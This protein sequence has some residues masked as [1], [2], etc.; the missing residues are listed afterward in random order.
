V[1]DQTLG[2]LENQI[3]NF[4]ETHNIIL[5]WGSKGQEPVDDLFKYHSRLVS[6]HL[7]NQVHKLFSKFGDGRG[8][9]IVNRVATPYFLNIGGH[10][11][12]YAKYSFKDNVCHDSSSGRQQERNNMSITVN[13][14]GGPNSVDCDE[15]QEHRIKNIKG[16]LD[17]LHGNH[18]PSNIEKA[19][20]SADLQLK[21]S[22]EIERAMNI[23]YSCAGTASRLLCDE[24]VA[25]IEKLMKEIKPFSKHR[26]EV[27]FV[28][29]LLE[30]DNFAKLESKSGLVSEF[31]ERNRKQYP[32]WG[33]F[34]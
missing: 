2:N 14:W 34:V 9:R 31:L 16:F 18:D 20:K 7:M 26:K 12:K 4:L 19:V 13:A 29:P 21:I 1:E 10:R 25:K 23:S 27:S 17:D 28:E 22:E 15:F 30:N 32:S 8:M 6:S 33:P 24:D 3:G 11:S 5:F